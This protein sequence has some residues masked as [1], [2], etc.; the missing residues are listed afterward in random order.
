MIELSNISKIYNGNFI[1]RDI[2]SSIID[3]DRIGL[4]GSNG[5]GKSTLLKIICGQE[6]PDSGQISISDKIKIGYLAQNSGLKTSNTIISEMRA[7]FKKIFNIK[8]QMEEMEKEASKTKL[9]SEK[10]SNKKKI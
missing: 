10:K 8:R 1:F 7:V 5:A 4:V 6:H 9:L 3:K 2:T